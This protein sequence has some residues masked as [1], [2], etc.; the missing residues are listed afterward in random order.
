MMGRA[1]SRKRV[2]I[3]DDQPMTC[4]GL[5]H[6]INHQPD[7]VLCAEVENAAAAPDAVDTC[8]PDRKLSSKM[9]I[10]ENP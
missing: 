10:R 4:A 1:K 9:M 2:L 5:V 8:E 3:I 7:L 6:V